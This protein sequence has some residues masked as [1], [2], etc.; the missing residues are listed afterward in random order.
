MDGMVKHPPCTVTPPPFGRLV[1]LA[2]AI[3]AR[4]WRR[5]WSRTFCGICILSSGRPGGRVYD[6]RYTPEVTRAIETAYP[7][8]ERVAGR[9]LRLPPG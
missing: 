7:N 1:L 5:R 2:T 6:S 3:L 4:W 9:T 8:I